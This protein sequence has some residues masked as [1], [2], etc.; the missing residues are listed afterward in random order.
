M[1]LS[2]LLVIFRRKFDSDVVNDKSMELDQKYI[3][4]I[5]T[6]PD[7]YFENFLKCFITIHKAKY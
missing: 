5:L 3:A 1:N 2:K 7:S 6:Q 4:K